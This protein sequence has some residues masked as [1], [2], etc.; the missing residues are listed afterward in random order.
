MLSNAREEIDVRPCGVLDA[1]ALDRKPGADTPGELRPLGIEIGRHATDLPQRH[2]PLEVAL[3]IATRLR[4]LA[5][6][7]AIEDERLGEVV[8]V[9]VREQPRPQVVVL[10]LEVFRVVPQAVRLEHLAVDEDARMEERAS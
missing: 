3:E 1:L 10:A 4:G 8:T 5:G 6:V 2:P 7:D 9:R